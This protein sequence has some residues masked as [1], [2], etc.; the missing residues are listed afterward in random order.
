MQQSPSS[1][2]QPVLEEEAAGQEGKLTA[3]S[4]GSRPGSAGRS[5]KGG[6]LA[7]P[8]AGGLRSSIS[9]RAGRLRASAGG[10][11]MLRQLRR[12][13]QIAHAQEDKL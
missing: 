12:S 7:I 6:A 3:R 13:V 4:A 11:Q 2:L 10:G 9:G 5:R 1:G 8:L